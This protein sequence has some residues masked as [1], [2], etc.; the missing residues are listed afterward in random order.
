MNR[1][2]LLSDRIAAAHLDRRRNRELQRQERI[3]NANVRT[4]GIDTDAL[5]HQVEEKRN[6]EEAEARALKEYTDGLICSDRTACLLEHRQKKDKRL[7]EEA[8]VGFRQQFQQPSSRR[9][10]DLNDPELLKKQDGVRILP[11]LP[12]EDLHSRERTRRQRE[13]LRD[14]SI[15]QQLELEHAKELQTLEDQQYDQSQLALDSR[16]LELQKMEEEH[17]RATAIA[18]KDFNQALAAEVIKRQ[19]NER[20]KEEEN[21]QADVLN[22]MQGELLSE[23]P[24]RVPGLTRV[25]RDCYKGLTPQQLMHYTNYQQQQAEEKRRARVQQREEE[26]QQDRERLALARAALLQERRQARISKEL[27]RA[28]DNTNTQL[29]QI[30]KAQRSYLEKEVYPNIPDESYFAQFNKTSR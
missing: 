19:E 3:F 24:Q 21:N 13:Q 10:F 5:D 7:L 2:E 22:Q 23:S 25:R 27:R 1:V 9:E 15:Q 17:K 26:L 28:L 18:I 8:I 12:G 29:A 20:R 30:Q 6:K 14:W 11:G 4:I 16:A